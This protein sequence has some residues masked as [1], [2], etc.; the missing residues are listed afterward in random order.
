MGMIA[1]PYGNSRHVRYNSCPKELLNSY[2]KNWK[3]KTTRKWVSNA[4]NERSWGGREDL[5]LKASS[6]TMW[7]M[8][9]EL[10][11]K[12]WSR[13][14]QGSWGKDIAGKVNGGSQGTE[15]GKDRGCLQISNKAH[16]VSWPSTANKSRLILYIE[17]FAQSNPVKKQDS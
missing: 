11:F 15:A 12:G 5:Q 9:F 6:E 16:S 8:G 13:L 1:G 17:S 7:E 3:Q 2:F 14:G 4:G 10:G